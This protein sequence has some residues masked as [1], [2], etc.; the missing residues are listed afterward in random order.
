[1]K[2][3]DEEIEKELARLKPIVPSEALKAKIG[4]ALEE[5]NSSS[6][7]SLVRFRPII[8][9][10]TAACL[11][12]V[13]TISISKTSNDIDTGSAEPQTVSTQVS[14]AAHKNSYVPLQAEQRLMEAFDE[15]IVFTEGHDPV[16]KLRYQFIDTLTMVDENDGS[17]FTMEIPREEILFVPVTML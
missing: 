5:S 12:F 2:H 1:M 3:F 16:R 11:I 4:S 6:A 9:L 14:K 8:A 7:I 10:A 15:G 13:F 17:V